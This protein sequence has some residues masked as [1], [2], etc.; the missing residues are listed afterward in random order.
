MLMIVVVVVVVLLLMM[1]MMLMVMVVLMV[2]MV[3]MMIVI[4]L[5]CRNVF[6]FLLFSRFQLRSV[7][8]KQSKVYD[9]DDK[10]DKDIDEGNHRVKV[11]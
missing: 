2:M 1:M 8:E 5:P 4:C 11:R 3:V 10:D 7:W 6:H 9:D